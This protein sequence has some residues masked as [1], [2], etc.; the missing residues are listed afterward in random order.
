MRRQSGGRAGVQ[1]VKARAVW[2]AAAQGC[3][4]RAAAA[5]ASGSKTAQQN[6]DEKQELAKHHEAAMQHAKQQQQPKE[7][8][9]TGPSR[10]DLK[11]MFHHLL[12]SM[13]EAE[14]KSLTL[15]LGKAS[16]KRTFSQM[17]DEVRAMPASKRAAL[18]PSEAKAA[19]LRMRRSLLLGAMESGMPAARRRRRKR[20]LVEFSPEEYRQLAAMLAS[21]PVGGYVEDAEGNIRLA[22]D[23][24]DGAD[25]EAAAEERAEPAVDVD[26]YD[27]ND[28]G[29][30]FE[31]WAEEP[32][33]DD[34]FPG[35][36]KEEE[37]DGSG[38]E[39]LQRNRR[40]PLTMFLVRMAGVKGLF[41]P[42]DQDR[43]EQMADELTGEAA[44]AEA[45]E[46]QAEAERRSQLEA[47][48]VAELKRFAEKKIPVSRWRSPRNEG[49]RPH[50][51]QHDALLIE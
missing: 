45:A 42:L 51:T 40:P 44:I 12:E 26:D 21:Q 16:V 41:V 24:R 38:R 50:A 37:E 34:N 5:K 22:A 49:L 47:A 35:E 2:R 8:Y 4:G 29:G 28:A 10:Q 17:K 11:E 23:D 32:V 25:P 33:R 31:G 15:R 6:R 14:R 18:P 39:K 13:T 46:A 9:E 30:L 1:P 3:G 36:E 7:R 20:D 43:A 48:G 19:V 27:N